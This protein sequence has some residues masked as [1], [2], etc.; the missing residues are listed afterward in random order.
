[1]KYATLLALAI[2]ENTAAPYVWQSMAARTAGKVF[3][4]KRTGQS[5]MGA[6][7]YR[8]TLGREHGE[9]R[10]IEKGKFERKMRR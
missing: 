7:L 6:E 3:S 2:A 5:S 1:M 4:G 9:G 8:Y 10:C